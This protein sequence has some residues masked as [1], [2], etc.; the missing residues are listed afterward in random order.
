MFFD[1]F[2]DQ[3]PACFKVLFFFGAQG[4]FDLAFG[5]GCGDEAEPL[6]LGYLVFGGQ[7]FHLV[8][9]LKDMAG[10]H[11]FL[12]YFGSDAFVAQVGMDFVGYIDD[13]GAFGEFDGFSLRG[14]HHDFRS[15]EVEFEFIEE[16][17]C[18]VFRILEVISYPFYPAVQ[19]VFGSRG[20]FVPVV[21]GEAIF[22]DLVHPFGADLHFYPFALGAH[23]GHV[24]RFVSV[25]AWHGDPVADPVRLGGVYVCH[26]RKHLK[27]LSFF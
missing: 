24:E 5:F 18:I 26:Q 15:E 12:V 17:K 25:G 10:G 20:V 6:L 13:S 22:R 9:V 23:D 11:Q 1:G 19:F 2:F 27:A 7:D 16:F 14:E 8:A 3:F 4:V 21:G